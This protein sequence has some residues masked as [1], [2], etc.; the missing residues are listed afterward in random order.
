MNND[1]MEGLVNSG[2]IIRKALDK[3]PHL[4]TN[5]S[6]TLNHMDEASKRGITMSA[7]ATVFTKGMVLTNGMTTTDNVPTKSPVFDSLADIIGDWSM[8]SRVLDALEDGEIIG[9]GNVVGRIAITLAE[10]DIALNLLDE[11][12]VRMMESKADAKDAH[13]AWN[14]AEVVTQLKLEIETGKYEVGQ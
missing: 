5:I 9:I 6:K 7:K 3:Y 1:G 14:P 2:E 4:S 11:L 8:A 12:M 13:A 10:K